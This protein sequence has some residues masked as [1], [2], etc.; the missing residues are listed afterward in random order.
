MTGVKSMPI[1]WLFCDEIDEYPGD[2]DGQAEELVAFFD[3]LAGVDAD[4]DGVIV[5]N[6]GHSP[7]PPGIWIRA[8]I[9]P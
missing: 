8:S 3:R 7:C 4:P 5:Q 9:L 1:R 6:A 2:V